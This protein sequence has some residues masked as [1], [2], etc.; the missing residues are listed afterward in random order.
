MLDPAAPAAPYVFLSYASA[1]RERALHVA[2]LLEGEG[3]RVWLDRQSIEGGASWSEQIV[4]SIRGCAALV[5]LATPQS[6]T[7]RN[8]RQEIQ[9]AW[10]YDRPVLPLLLEPIS[11]PETIQYAR[12]GWQWVE[13]LDRPEEVWLPA[14]LRALNRLDTG[15]RTAAPAFTADLVTP[16]SGPAVCHGSATSTRTPSVNPPRHNLPAS[17]TT[18]IG[19]ESEVDAIGERLLRAA[20]RLLTLTG[21]GGTGK[22]RLSLQVAAELLAHFPSGVYFVSLAPIIA[23]NLVLQRDFEV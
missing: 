22:T 7:S 21:P 13:V 20:V 1:D 19:R 9:L 18:F 15:R 14:I 4:Q 12:A 16:A 10:E 5:L 17:L 3:I 11:Y 6:L 2:D 23:P 8:V